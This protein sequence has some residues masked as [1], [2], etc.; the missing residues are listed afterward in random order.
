MKNAR[1][2]LTLAALLACL[3][4]TSCDPATYY[5]VTFDPNGGQNSGKARIT[6][7]E[8]DRIPFEYASSYYLTPPP[9]DYQMRGW[10]REPEKINKWDFHRDIVTS[11]ITLY[12]RWELFFPLTFH[13]NGGVFHNS[14]NSETSTI[15]LVSKGD[16]LSVPENVIRP[17]YFVEGWY[18]DPELTDRWEFTTD[19]ISDERTLYA[20]WLPTIEGLTRENY[21]MV[22]GATS[23][24]ALNVLIA[25]KLLGLPYYH[26]KIDAT[27]EMCVVPANE[28]LYAGVFLNGHIKTSQTYDA[29]INLIQGRVDIILRSTTASPDEQAAAQAAGVSLIETPVALDAFIFLK[30]NDNLVQSL[31]LDQIRKIYTKQITNWREVGGRKA[32]IKVFSRPRNSGSEEAFRDLVMG[33]I[34]PAEFPEE[35]QRPASMIGLFWELEKEPNGIGYIFQNYKEMIVQ[36][37]EPVFSIDGIQPTPA[38]IKNRTYPLTTEVY[39]IIRSDLDH[40]S[41]AYKLYEWLQTPAARITFEESGF[42]PIP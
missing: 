40:G 33:D 34:E 21:P 23:T 6:V 17:G 30:H 10:Y 7:A 8:G 11:D 2:L 3:S 32:A 36:R 25:C 24:R 13:A 38:T 1:H 31:T 9:G 27:Q 42:T 39:A 12:A 15:D 18:R 26:D 37:H 16:G 35:Q 41:M 5:T 28:S 20:K 4:L 14:D 19:V 29:M 22:D